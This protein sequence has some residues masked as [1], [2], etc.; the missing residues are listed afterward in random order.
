MIGLTIG[1]GVGAGIIINN[2]LYAGANCGAGEFG[3]VDYLDKIYEYYCSGSFFKNVYNLNGEEV[4]KKAK[5]GDKQALKL[6]AELGYH[7]GNAIK[8]IIY[9]YDPLLI[10]L[11]GSV[12]LAYNF[13]T[14]NVAKN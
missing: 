10:I 8:M 7:I 4:F 12:R 6:Y 3:T 9:T 5:Q 13:L 1:T 2:K 11:G 14:K